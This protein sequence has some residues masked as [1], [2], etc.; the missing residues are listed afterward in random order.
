M[1]TKKAAVDNFKTRH[2]TFYT[3]RLY[4]VRHTGQIDWLASNSP[5]SVLSLVISQSRNVVVSVDLIQRITI[6]NL[7][8][9]GPVAARV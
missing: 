7:I 6:K 8:G 4:A 1:L 5:P 9:P 3:W 2:S